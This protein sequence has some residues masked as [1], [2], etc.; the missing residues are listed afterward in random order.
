LKSQQEQLAL[1][2]KK[3]AEETKPS[4]ATAAAAERSAIRHRQSRDRG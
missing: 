2:Q 3:L 4:E 1:L